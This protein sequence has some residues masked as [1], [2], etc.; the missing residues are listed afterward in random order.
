MSSHNSSPRGSLDGETQDLVNSDAITGSTGIEVKKE[1]AD[2]DEAASTTSAGEN[3]KNAVEKF[4][5]R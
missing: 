1:E 2:A 3:V 5:N 4:T